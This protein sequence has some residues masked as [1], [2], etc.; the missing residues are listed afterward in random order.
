MKRHTATKAHTSLD[1]HAITT[2]LGTKVVVD[3]LG[4]YRQSTTKGQGMEEPE[5]PGL[6]PSCFTRRV[7]TSLVPKGF[8]LPHDQQI[9]D[10][11]QEPSSWLSDYLQTVRIHAGSKETAMQ[12]LQLHL[13][14][15]TRSW[16]SKLERETIG[17]WEELTKQFTSNFKSTYKRP[18]SI[19]EVKACV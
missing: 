5:G 19:E 14:S 2:V 16:L 7:C 18:A 13:T 9:Y 12:S 11:S 17:S 4:Q 3:D 6:P 15:E 1:H 8:K 10:G